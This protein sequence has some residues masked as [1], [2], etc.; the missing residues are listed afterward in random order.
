VIGA[1]NCSSCDKNILDAIAQF[2]LSQ[3]S[4]VFDDLTCLCKQEWLDQLDIEPF[5]FGSLI[6]FSQG[7][8]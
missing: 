3:D 6:D 7:V 2:S 4:S 5:S 1:H 8:V